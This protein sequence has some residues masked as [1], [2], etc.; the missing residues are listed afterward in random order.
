MWV[1][2]LFKFLFIYGWLPQQVISSTNVH[3]GLTNCLHSL[4]KWWL[5]YTLAMSYLPPLGQ[6]TTYMQIYKFG[7]DFGNILLDEVWTICNVWEISS[8]FCMPRI[9]L[10]PNTFFPSCMLP[11]NLYNTL[12]SKKEIQQFPCQGT[13]LFI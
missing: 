8:F 6:S 2:F 13:I 7:N 9:I 10:G 4:F 1:F 12:K 11:N 3:R 5:M